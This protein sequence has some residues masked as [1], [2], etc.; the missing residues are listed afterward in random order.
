[1]TK[2]ALMKELEDVKTLSGFD[3]E[4]IMGDVTAPLLRSGKVTGANLLRAQQLA[5]NIAAMN[6]NDGEALKASGEKLSQA[7]SNPMRAMRLVREFMSP[8]EFERLKKSMKGLKSSQVAGMQDKILTALEG[9]YRGAAKS[10][11]DSISTTLLRV[12]GAIG[13]VNAGI[14]NFLN[15]LLG[16][17]LREWAI[18]AQE[19]ASTFSGLGLELKKIEGF[20]GKL[21]F[22]ATE[23]E[24]AT[25]AVRAFTTAVAALAAGALVAV[26]LMFGK[27]G[28]AVAV[29]TAALAGVAYYWEPIKSNALLAGQAIQ[30]FWGSFSRT[31][32]GI[33]AISALKVA[34]EGVAT[35][36]KFLYGNVELVITALQKLFDIASKVGSVVGKVTEFVGGAIGIGR[37]GQFDGGDAEANFYTG[38]GQFKIPAAPSIQG[39]ETL[40]ARAE[41][42]VEGQVNVTINDKSGAATVSSS[43][44]GNVPVNVGKTAGGAYSSNDRRLPPGR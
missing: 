39:M 27:V 21:L 24:Q 20:K 22:L 9:K 18:S 36:V 29:V 32:V 19:L 43:S 1:M 6:G 40:G 35:Y 33:T 23:F 12:R 28:A 42:K 31:D 13:D 30:T 2:D 25:P 5:A 38:G 17:K 16:S 7:L 10:M 41:A 11:S 34:F 4:D 15:A 3:V 44:T 8:E 37:A 14:G 26:V